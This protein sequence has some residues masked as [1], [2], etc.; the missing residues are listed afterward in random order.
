MCFIILTTESKLY[1]VCDKYKKVQPMRTQSMQG[2]LS[3]MQFGTAF[4]NTQ[5]DVGTNLYFLV[6]IL[7]LGPTVSGPSFGPVP[8][9]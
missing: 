6:F 5:V 2:A 3:T 4:G 1:E 7:D 8:I 9:C